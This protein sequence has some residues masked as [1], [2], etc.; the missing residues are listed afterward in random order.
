MIFWIFFLIAPIVLKCYVRVWN[1]CLYHVNFEKVCNVEE[2]SA[3]AAYSYI[4]YYYLFFHPLKKRGPDWVACI[5]TNVPFR[6][7]LSYVTK[8]ALCAQR[9]LSASLTS[10][11][12]HTLATT[13]RYKVLRQRYQ[14]A[15]RQED[16]GLS[17]RFR[18]SSAHQLFVTRW[19][20]YFNSWKFVS[21]QLT[22]SGS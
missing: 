18:L 4:Y 17:T 20:V 9:E 1:T 2:E 11:R 6:L 7:E 19:K 10:Q 5:S 21:C 12:H 14:R 22:A 16:G 3:I 8:G 15:R 13:H